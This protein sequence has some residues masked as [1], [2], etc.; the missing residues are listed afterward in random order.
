MRKEEV[1]WEPEGG[2]VTQ[3]MVQKRLDF[4][5]CEKLCIIFVRDNPRKVAAVDMSATLLCHSDPLWRLE[6]QSLVLIGSPY[7]E[8]AG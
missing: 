4:Q 2:Q 8:P 5:C 1:G 6:V 3:G 7:P